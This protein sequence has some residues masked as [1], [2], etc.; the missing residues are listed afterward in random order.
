MEFF[1]RKFASTQTLYWQFKFSSLHPQALPS[2]HLNLEGSI[3]LPDTWNAPKGRNADGAKQFLTLPWMRLFAIR[4][5]LVASEKA[6]IYLFPL[7]LLVKSKADW[8]F[9]RCYGNRSRK[10]INLKVKLVKLR[11]KID[12]VLLFSREA[13]LVN[14]RARAHTHIHTH[15]H[16]YIYTRIYMSD[17]RKSHPGFDPS[18]KHL[19]D[20]AS[21]KGCDT[22]KECLGMIIYIYIY[23]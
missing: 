22:K 18:L 12:L 17:W 11:L 6:W 19:A 15:T 2:S 13:G 10:R 16:I 3:S 21:L 1:G 7:Q 9:L 8:S 4:I 14:T 5:A 20:L 23:T